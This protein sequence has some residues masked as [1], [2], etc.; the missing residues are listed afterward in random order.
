MHDLARLVGDIGG[1]GVIG[2]GAGADEDEIAA[3]GILAAEAEPAAGQRH[4][5]GC[6]RGAARGDHGVVQ[7]RDRFPIGDVE[8]DADH[9]G[10]GAALQPKDM[11]IARGAAE[12]DGVVAPLDRGEPPYIFIEARRLVE[13]GGDEIDAAQAAN[14]AVGHGFLYVGASLPRL[15]A[16]PKSIVQEANVASRAATAVEKARV[17]PV[18]SGVTPVNCRNASIA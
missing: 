7:R 11:V 10:L 9:R 13:I 12:I 15:S 6:G 5:A 18:R 3:V 4:R 17:S 14:E 2:A 8:H 1:V 16:A